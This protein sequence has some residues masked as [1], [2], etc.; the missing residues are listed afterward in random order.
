MS[1]VFSG[2]PDAG[3]LILLVYLNHVATEVKASSAGIDNPLLRTFAAT[4]WRVRLAT[5]VAAKATPPTHT[6]EGLLEDM[7]A[8]DRPS[9]DRDRGSMATAR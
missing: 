9:V 6:R 8:H 1:D 2:G 4:R 3:D 5:R 7:R